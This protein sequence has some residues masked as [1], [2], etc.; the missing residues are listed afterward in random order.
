MK[1]YII[2]RLSAVIINVVDNGRFFFRR[3]FVRVTH[4]RACTA[5]ARTTIS[6]PIGHVRFFPR[7]S[8]RL[9]GGRYFFC[10]VDYAA[11]VEFGRCG[12]RTESEMHLAN[13]PFRENGTGCNAAVPPVRKCDP[14]KVGVEVVRRSSNGRKIK[15]VE[16]LVVVNRKRS[17]IF[18]SRR[19]KTL[20]FKFSNLTNWKKFGIDLMF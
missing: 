3:R 5:R 8:P 6:S 12:P 1:H 19:K 4:M 2:V 10:T 11:V 16:P 7:F 9:I 18:K 14:G 20:I 17:F 15:L 13:R